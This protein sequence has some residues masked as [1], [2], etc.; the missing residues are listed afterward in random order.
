MGFFSRFLK[1]GVVQTFASLAGCGARKNLP[2]C[3]QALTTD[4]YN[5]AGVHLS[6]TTQMTTTV[7]GCVG[8]DAT[9]GSGSVT[10]AATIK[11]VGSTITAVA[12]IGIRSIACFIFC[13]ISHA[14]VMAVMTNA[15][16][17]SICSSNRAKNSKQFIAVDII[18]ECPNIPVLLANPESDSC[19]IGTGKSRF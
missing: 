3:K 11:A 1:N 8:K 16:L 13:T 7:T 9:V 15:K 5:F 2:S 4:N 18:P 14:I 19:T 6:K 10:T 12:K 17:K